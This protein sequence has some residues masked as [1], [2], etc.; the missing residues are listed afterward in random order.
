M[1]NMEYFKYLGSLKTNVAKCTSEVKSKIANGK[2]DIEQE[3]WFLKPGNWTYIYGEKI[4]N[5]YIWGMARY[6]VETWT[7][8]KVDQQIS[9]PVFIE[10]Y[11][12]GV[13]EFAEFW[14]LTE[15]M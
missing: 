9:V 10:V 11:K 12:Y 5:C 15:Y 7:L 3:H 2:S 8:R 14:Y 4:V 6:D 13:G 1:E